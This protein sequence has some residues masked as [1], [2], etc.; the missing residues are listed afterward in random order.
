MEPIRTHPDEAAQEGQ[1]LD[2]QIF[3]EN[4]R[5]KHGPSFSHLDL[6]CVSQRHETKLLLRSLLSSRSQMI[7]YRQDAATTYQ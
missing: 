5:L 1:Y 4:A 3:A 6:Y 2:H 7:G